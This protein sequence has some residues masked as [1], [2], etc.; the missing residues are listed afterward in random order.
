M[1][2]L[3]NKTNSCKLVVLVYTYIYRFIFW[4]GDFMNELKVLEVFQAILKRDKIT[5]TDLSKVYGTTPQ[6]IAKIF[7]NNDIGIEK[8]KKLAAAAGYDVKIDFIKKSADD[9]Q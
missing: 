6:N 3:Y 5:F 1:V 9:L 4:V 8:L 2:I 7:K